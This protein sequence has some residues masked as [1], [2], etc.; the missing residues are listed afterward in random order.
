MSWQASWNPR[1]VSTQNVDG[2]SHYH[3][4]CA[5]PEAPVTMHTP[6]VWAGIR[7]TT[8]TAISFEVVFA[9]GHLFSIFG[10]PEQCLSGR[11]LLKRTITDS[12]HRVTLYC[13]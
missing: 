4:D 7:L 12:A 10:I 3:E 11:L 2:D 1:Q 9:A 5:D 8:I 6:P 13:F